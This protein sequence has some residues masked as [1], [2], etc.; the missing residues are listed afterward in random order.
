VLRTLYTHAAQAVHD[1]A[2]LVRYEEL[3]GAAFERILPAFGMTLDATARASVEWLGSQHAK[4][5]DQPFSPDSEA[6]RGAASDA[7]RALV[8]TIARPA[9][10][11]L[12]GA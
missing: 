7:L 4:R 1:G 6:K 8:D 10:V 3:P 2:L 12:V 5:V 9:Y 11:K